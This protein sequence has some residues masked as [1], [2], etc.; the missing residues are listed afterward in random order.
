MTG[1]WTL[2]ALSLTRNI[3]LGISHATFPDVH[4]LYSQINFSAVSNKRY[5]NFDLA[6]Y[7]TVHPSVDRLLHTLEVFLNDA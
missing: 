5:G 1:A 2:E 7:C 3:G 4:S 6:G